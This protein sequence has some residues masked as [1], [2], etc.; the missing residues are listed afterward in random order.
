M[1]V[2]ITGGIGTGKSTVVS[3]FEKLGDVAVY[4]ADDEAKNL[5]N[6]SQVIASKIKK[7]FG[8]EAYK[9]GVL[10]R[11]FLAN[12]V[13]KDKEKLSKLNA[14]V[15]PEVAKHFKEFVKNNQHK[16]YVLY[17]NAI[18][19]ENKSDTF[20]DVIITITAP[21]DV[22]LQRLIT[23]DNTTKE[24]VLHR[25]NN[26]WSETKKVLQSN[27]IIENNDLKNTKETVSKIHTLLVQKKNL[28]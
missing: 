19:F 2:G 27:Y 21:L 10:N 9:K 3:L 1:I 4:T 13:F 15:H 12:I 14:I 28:D 24:A 25:I 22:R 17:E 7:E 16:L 26:Q 18:L 20:C 11:P 6:T 5:M 23:R 8:D